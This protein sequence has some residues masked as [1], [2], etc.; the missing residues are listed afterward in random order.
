MPNLPRFFRTPTG[1]A[2]EYHT[3]TRGGDL[4]HELPF[5]YAA[6]A[7]NQDGMEL[8]FEQ[9]CRLQD[10][11]DALVR[12]KV[13]EQRR[14]DALQE[15]VDAYKASLNAVA[16]RAARD[17]IEALKAEVAGLRE[18]RDELTRV[19]RLANEFRR[20][21]SIALWGHDSISA[22]DQDRLDGISA[23]VECPV[24]LARG[25]KKHM[26]PVVTA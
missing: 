21:V 6:E 1:P 9:A 13:A 18:T 23:L 24:C 10:A 5:R 11:I 26:N 2:V 15:A 7:D 25:C 22:C 16:L 12:E 14:A 3:P 4:R 20:N 19:L 8:I 17:E